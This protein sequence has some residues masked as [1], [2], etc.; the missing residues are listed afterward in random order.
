LSI[1][2]LFQ[3]YRGRLDKLLYVPLP[4]PDDRVSIL[5]ALSGKMRL[6]PDVDLSKIGRSARAVGYSGADCAALLRE[7]GLAVLKED[8]ESG[9]VGASLSIHQRHFNY[10]F[11]HVVPSVS[12]KDQARYNRMRDRMA[13][14]RT[15]GAVASESAE[16]EPEDEQIE[17][18]IDAQTTDAVI[19][20]G[21]QLSNPSEKEGAASNGGGGN[22]DD[23][24]MDDGASSVNARTETASIESLPVPTQ[25]AEALSVDGVQRFIVK[26]EDDGVPN[27]E[28]NGVTSV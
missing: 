23:E 4:T 3:S 24:V 1:F 2:C 6:A 27:G 9:V 25:A 17:V 14:A 22:N 21:S 28:Q 13:H 5:K 19:G 10:A 7:A 20:E 18:T 26:S 8:V 12:E 16:G 15:R 11:S